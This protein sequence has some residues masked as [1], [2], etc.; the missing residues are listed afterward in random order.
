MNP[1]QQLISYTFTDGP[2]EGRGYTINGVPPFAMF[3]IGGT[4]EEPVFHLYRIDDESKEKPAYK[5]V[6]TYLFP[7]VSRL[8]FP[9]A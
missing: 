7:E 5:F 1:D 8:M 4:N 2:Y 9:S 6:K 3:M